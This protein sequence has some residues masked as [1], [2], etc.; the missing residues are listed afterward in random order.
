MVSPLAVVTRIQPEGCVQDVGGRTV[1]VGETVSTW[2]WVGKVGSAVSVNGKPMVVAV[3]VGKLSGKVGGIS[4]GVADCG[5][6]SARE[7][8][9]PPTTRMTEKMAMITPPPNWRQAC[10]IN[11]PCS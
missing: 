10:I 3:G 8:K 2:V 1:L 7:R 6:V 9:I 4:E 5:K 11:S